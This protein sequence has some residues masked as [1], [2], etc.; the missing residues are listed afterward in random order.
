MRV[1]LCWLYCAGSSSQKL[2]DKVAE[3]AL[4]RAEKLK[5][6][7]KAE[8]NKPKISVST[9]TSNQSASRIV[10][11][12]GIEGLSLR[13]ASAQGVTDASSIRPKGGPALTDEEKKVLAVTSLINGRE[14]LPFM[15]HIDLKER[16][17]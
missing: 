14:Y 9:T 1:M 3:Y 10:P 15:D 5:G 13:E 11:P 8:Q 16:F 4:D 6:I 17:V 12:L 7:N 2:T